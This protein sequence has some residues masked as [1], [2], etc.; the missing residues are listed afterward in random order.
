MNAATTFNAFHAETDIVVLG[1][2]PEAADYSN[3]R[4]EIHGFS[5]YVC[6]TNDR[7]DTRVLHVAT[8]RN[9]AEV[10]DK[11]DR[12]AQ[13]LTA[14]LANLGKLPVGFDTWVAGRAVYGS[15]AYEAYGAADDM[16]FERDMEACY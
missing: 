16:A 4:G 7:G 14:R 10:L 1:T 11:A 12:L 6:A 8:S 3:P 15:A 9:E 13:C 5:A 2:N